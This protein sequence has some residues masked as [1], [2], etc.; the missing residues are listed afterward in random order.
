[1]GNDK[2]ISGSPSSSS[3]NK[4]KNKSISISNSNS[5]NLEKPK[6][7]QRGLGVAQ[8]EKIR[9]HS[10]MASFGFIPQQYP[11]FPNPF[12]PSPFQEDMRAQ[13]AYH[14]AAMQSA[15]LYGYGPS[16]SSSSLHGYNHP[17]NFM[18]GLGGQ[19]Q[20][21]SNIKFG[22][23]QP[24]MTT[25]WNTNNNNNIAA[26][27]NNQFIQRQGIVTRHFLDNVERKDERGNL[28]KLRESSSYMLE[29]SDDNEGLDLELKL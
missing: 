12:P 5:S 17:N 1:M 21:S 8:L 3:P 4:N 26:T 11:F 28:F 2:R 6:Q 18:M 22:E 24:S 27:E 15:T 19:M 13:A 23:S 16:S 20:T 14:Q 25:R 29:S 10:Q 9:L 7:P